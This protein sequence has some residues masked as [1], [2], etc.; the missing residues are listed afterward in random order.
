MQLGPLSLCFRPKS[1]LNRPA[2]S[3]LPVQD[4]PKDPDHIGRV[5]ERGF[6][7]LESAAPLKRDEEVH[8]VAH[9]QIDDFREGKAI[10]AAAAERIPSVHRASAH[11]RAR[12]SDGFA[13]GLVGN[14]RSGSL[15][16][17]PAVVAHL[18]T[19]DRAETAGRSNALA[20]S[21]RSFPPFRSYLDEHVSIARDHAS[22]RNDQPAWRAAHQR[23]GYVLGID[24]HDIGARTHGQ[25]V[26]VT[27]N[28]MPAAPGR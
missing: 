17:P 10:D 7:D 2:V 4:N 11:K 1:R 18:K 13:D 14:L 9:D 26:H 15:P 20:G 5:E 16:S 19:Y 3:F 27:S 28:E 23:I 24:Q 12:R 21:A 22:A 6:A 25:V 8:G